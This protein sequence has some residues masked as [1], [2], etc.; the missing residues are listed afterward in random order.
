MNK[1]KLMV[2]AGISDAEGDKREVW[3]ITHLLHILKHTQEIEIRSL[4]ESWK[5]A[6]VR[7]TVTSAQPDFLCE[8]SVQTHKL[9]QKS[10]VCMNKNYKHGGRLL[11]KN[12]PIQTY[13]ELDTQRTVHFI[14]FHQRQEVS[15]MGTSILNWNTHTHTHTH[16][17]IIKSSTRQG[18]GNDNATTHLHKEKLF[19]I[20]NVGSLATSRFAMQMVTVYL[21]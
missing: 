9:T 15:V 3:V 7:E 19:L 20:G 14:K 10:D 16:T 8:S 12:T 2:I 11:I 18:A 21:N 13:L 4:P 6:E 17:R 5:E 1:L